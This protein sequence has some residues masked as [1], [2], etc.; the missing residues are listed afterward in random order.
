MASLSYVCPL[1][2]PLTFSS[3]RRRRLAKEKQEKKTGKEEKGEKNHEIEQLR[4]NIDVFRFQVL[5]WLPIVL[6][7]LWAMVLWVTVGL[8][9]HRRRENQNE[10]HKTANGHFFF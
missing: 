10:K 7:S 3:H 6:Q 9:R 4:G 1:P 5:E 2:G 8:G